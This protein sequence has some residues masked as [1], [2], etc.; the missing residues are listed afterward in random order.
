MAAYSPSSREQKKTKKQQQKNL[1]WPL[2]ALGMQ[3]IHRH[4]RR[5]STQKHKRDVKT[6]RKIKIKLNTLKNVNF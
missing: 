4:I 5:Q 2:W 6:K 1:F 3:E